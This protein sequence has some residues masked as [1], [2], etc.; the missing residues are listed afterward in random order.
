V[1][2]KTKHNKTKS[3]NINAFKYL[4]IQAKSLILIEHTGAG[5]KK[6]KLILAPSEVREKNLD[7]FLPTIFANWGKGKLAWSK[8]ESGGVVKICHPYFESVHTF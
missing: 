6:P 8:A 2:N 1:F 3:L 4:L 7:P 5:L